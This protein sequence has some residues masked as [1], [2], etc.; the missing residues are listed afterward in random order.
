ML[1][2]HLKRFI[3]ERHAGEL[4]EH[5]RID[6][7]RALLSCTNR[8]GFVSLSLR[9]KNS[10]YSYGVNRLVNVVHELFVHLRDCYPDYLARNFDVREE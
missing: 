4:P 6:P 1:Y 9:V 2:S 3:Q 7:A 8:S 10:Q 5:R